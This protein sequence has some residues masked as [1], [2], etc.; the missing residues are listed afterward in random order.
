MKTIRTAGQ[1]TSISSRADKSLRLSIVTPELSVTERAEFMELQGELLQ[2]IFIPEEHQTEE[3][4]VEADLDGKSPSER[5]RNV[6]FVYWKKMS[7]LGK[8]KDDFSL[9]YRNNLEYI[10][11]KYK[12]KIEEL[13]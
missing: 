2:A 7:D 13:E 11:E 5:Q 10:I 4:K 8:I 6:M 12:E 1:I 3:M 9:W